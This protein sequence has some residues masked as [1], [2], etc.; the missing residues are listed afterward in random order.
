MKNGARRLDGC[1]VAVLE[2]LERAR[3]RED[4][5]PKHDREVHVWR[6]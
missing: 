4:D 5:D 6:E 3:S 1:R 2:V